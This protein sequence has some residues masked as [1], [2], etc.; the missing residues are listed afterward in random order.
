VL[1]HTPGF[2]LFF[3]V[4]LAA[5]LPARGTRF[6]IPVIVVF[7][8]IFYGCW[9][10]KFLPLLWVTIIVDYSLGNLVAATADP[11]KRRWLVAASVATNLGILAYFK[12]WNFAVTSALPDAYA[13]R[14]TV[15]DVI[16]PLGIS[17]Y[18]FQSMSYVIDAG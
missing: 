14:L 4:F 3:A 2:L 10:W 1:F 11:R 9:N 17:F 7:S 6:A 15:V 13:A 16:L 18:V 8:S 12:Y 5:Y